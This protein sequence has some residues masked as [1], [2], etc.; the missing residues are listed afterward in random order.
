[1]KSFISKS[2]EKLKSIKRD[3]S[4]NEVFFPLWIE[5]KAISQTTLADACPRQNCD[6]RSAPSGYFIKPSLNDFWS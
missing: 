4:V 2:D 3:E 5:C 6:H 1:M